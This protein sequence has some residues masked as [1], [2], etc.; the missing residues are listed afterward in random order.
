MDRG[1]REKG[2]V[3]V[4]TSA[5]IISASEPVAQDEIQKLIDFAREQEPGEI[6]LSPEKA[7]EMIQKVGTLGAAKEK[8]EAASAFIA[9]EHRAGRIR[10][11]KSL[12][13]MPTGRAR[14]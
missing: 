8:I 13:T 1:S 4:G 2:V 6:I 14:T 3:A 10:S 5:E 9:K 12:L 11:V 7:R